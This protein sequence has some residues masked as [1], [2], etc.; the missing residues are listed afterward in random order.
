MTLESYF[1]VKV[2]LKEIGGAALQSKHD[3][4]THWRA[5]LTSFTC[6]QPAVSS[7]AEHDAHISHLRTTSDQQTRAGARYPSV[8]CTPRGHHDQNNSS[9]PLGTRWDASR[10]E[11]C[12]LA[13]RSHLNLHITPG[14]P[15]KLKPPDTQK[16]TQVN[17]RN[18]GLSFSRWFS[19][20]CFKVIY[21]LCTVFICCD[22]YVCMRHL[23]DYSALFFCSVMLAWFPS[24]TSFTAGITI[25]S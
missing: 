21:F 1:K 14:S 11:T 3:P 18:S 15:G 7:P 2:T 6:F 5:V 13:V 23:K 24:K 12:Y 22:V 16:K 9:R 17:N 8:A 19:V 20:R 25:P 4:Q 10:S